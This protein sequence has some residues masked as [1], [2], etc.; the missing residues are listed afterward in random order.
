MIA[1]SHVPGKN[2]I[3]SDGN[4]ATGV[5]LHV[6]KKL[7]FVLQRAEHFG[8]EL[9]VALRASAVSSWCGHD[10]RLF[11]LHEHGLQA[12]ALAREHLELLQCRDKF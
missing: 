1:E 9:E 6:A 8:L 7:V 3:A 4:H 11:G 10:V 12:V 5:D 2:F